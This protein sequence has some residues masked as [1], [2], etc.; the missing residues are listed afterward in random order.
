MSFRKAMELYR[1]LYRKTLKI[2]I[3][4]QNSCHQNET[5]ML[6]NNNFLLVHQIIQHGM[7]LIQKTQSREQTKISTQ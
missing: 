7:S 2:V 4:T 6:L 1:V 3:L 5:Q